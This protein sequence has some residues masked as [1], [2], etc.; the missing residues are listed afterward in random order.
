ME[1]KE[2]GEY[3]DSLNLDLRTGAD[4]EGLLAEH[5]AGRITRKE[6][7]ALSF[8]ALAQARS[9]GFQDGFESGYSK[10][11]GLLKNN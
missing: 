8:L 6:Y 5:E 3:I 10:I 2:R 7:I 4:V 11:R 1:D 9:R